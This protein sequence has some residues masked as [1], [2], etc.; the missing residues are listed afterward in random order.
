MRHKPGS[1]LCDVIQFVSFIAPD[2]QSI[3]W[4]AGRVATDHELLALL[5]LVL[6]PSPALLA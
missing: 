1:H 3:E 4:I 2:D 5:Q 6:E